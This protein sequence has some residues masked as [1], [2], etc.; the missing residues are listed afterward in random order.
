MD[1]SIIIVSWNTR[2]WLRRCLTSIYAQPWK[3]DFEVFVID[4]ASSDGSPQMVRHAFPQVHLIENHQNLGF[5]RACNQG[6]RRARG[7]FV[8]LLNPDTQ[9]LDDA[10]GDMVAF[11]DKHPDIGALGPRIVDAN[12]NVDPRCARRLPTLSTELFEKTRLDRRF[13]H[14]QLFGRYLMTYWDHNDSRDVEAL[15][16]ACLMIRR[17]VLDRVGMLDEDFFMYGEDIDWCHRIRQAG[18]RVYYYSNAQIIHVAGQSAN[19]VYGD[20]GIEALWSLNRFFHKHHGLCYALAHRILIGSISLAKELLFAGGLL[21]TQNKTYYRTRL[22]LH[23]RVLKWAVMGNSPVSST[24]R[25]F[26]RASKEQL[27]EVEAR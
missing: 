18:W 8:V 17:E 12:G 3:I 15:S 6:L 9:L 19:L 23:W 20:M 22:R 14:S 25:G 1:L 24:R 2:Q 10:F 27:E 11:L 5:A 16:G 21:F 4:N 7:R 13:L 26:D